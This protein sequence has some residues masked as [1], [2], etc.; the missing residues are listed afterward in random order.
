MKSNLQ[1][2]KRKKYVRLKKNSAGGFCV[3]WESSFLL[4]PF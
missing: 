1:K 3:R 4:Y 2:E